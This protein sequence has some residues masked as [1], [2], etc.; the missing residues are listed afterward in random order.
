MYWAIKSDELK[1]TALHYSPALS[2][3]IYYTLALVKE[4]F[5]S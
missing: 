5:L 4:E 1:W 2:R 3:I